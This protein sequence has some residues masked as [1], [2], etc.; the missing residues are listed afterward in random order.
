MVDKDASAPR[1]SDDPLLKDLLA[2]IEG[3]LFHADA[4][5]Q[6]DLPSQAESWREA[7]KRIR[8]YRDSLESIPP[9]PSARTVT[10]YRVIAC[11]RRGEVFTVVDGSH[12][13]ADF[14]AETTFVLA[15][16][17]DPLLMALAQHEMDRATALAIL[18]TQSGDDLC[19]AC[20]QVKQVAISE[21]DNSDNAL[22][23][24]ADAETDVTDAITA[25][26]DAQAVAIKLDRELRSQIEDL[27]ATLAERAQEIRDALVARDN[28]QEIAFMLDR[29]LH[30][31]IH[32]L[33]QERD[34]LLGQV[35]LTLAR[36]EAAEVVVAGQR[37]VME[38]QAKKYLTTCE[39]LRV[40]EAFVAD[41]KVERDH[42]KRALTV[43]P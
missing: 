2:A 28:A 5:E 21:A 30:L 13:Y 22:A 43:S 39:Q 25:R 20:R 4:L 29:E 32:L 11:G 37:N 15:S 38:A 33:R 9:V 31:E 35:H 10:R 26:D 18:D 36:A 6:R 17:V 24:L 42:L 34:Q 14:P 23:A 41:L 19:D 8:A 1:I 40:S 7:A 16:E 12:T 27:E 3:C